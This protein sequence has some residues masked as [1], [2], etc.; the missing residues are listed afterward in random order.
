MMKYPFLLEDN[1]GS[2]D[3]QDPWLHV[4]SKDNRIGFS[5][6]CHLLQHAREDSLFPLFLSSDSLAFLNVFEEMVSQMVN[7]IGRE[8][9]DLVFFCIF[10][11]VSQNFNIEDQQASILLLSFLRNLGKSCLHG[12]H[13]IFLWHRANCH[14]WNRNFLVLKVD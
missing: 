4:D 1:N 14:V 5:E 10:L 8:Y 12:L 7:D 11:S 9:S 3:L 13:H 6:G 2:T